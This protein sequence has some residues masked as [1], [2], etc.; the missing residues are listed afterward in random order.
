MKT[1]MPLDG[2]EGPLPPLNAHRRRSAPTYAWHQRAQNSTTALIV[3]PSG[4]PGNCR[5]YECAAPGRQLRWAAAGW[6]GSTSSHRVLMPGGDPL[7]IAD[8][9]RVQP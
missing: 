9:P 2:V 6:S 1:S 4:F 5:D 3:L 7:Q 8:R